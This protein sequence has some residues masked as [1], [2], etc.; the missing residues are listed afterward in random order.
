MDYFA[1]TTCILD[2]LSSIFAT[3]NTEFL[4]RVRF[5]FPETTRLHLSNL[6]RAAGGLS[7]MHYPTSSCVLRLPPRCLLRQVVHQ[8]SNICTIDSVEQGP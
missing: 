5:L 2:P 8:N 4:S 3:A 1:R 6:A 7:R